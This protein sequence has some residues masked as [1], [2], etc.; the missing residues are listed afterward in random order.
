[1]NTFY[2]YHYLL[3]SD[4]VAEKQYSGACQMSVFW[5]ALLRMLQK[6]YSYIRVQSCVFE[7]VSAFKFPLTY[8]LSPQK[9]HFLSIYQGCTYDINQTYLKR[10]LKRHFFNFFN[11]FTKRYFLETIYIS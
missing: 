3:I 10:F 9:F 4:D 8:F 2:N 5:R 11:I 6:T 7:C 1:M